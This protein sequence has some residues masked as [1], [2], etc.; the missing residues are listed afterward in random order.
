MLTETINIF[1]DNVVISS[2]KIE[3]S[4]N[5]SGQAVSESTMH[6]NDGEWKVSYQTEWEYETSG[7]VKKSTFTRMGD[8]QCLDKVIKEYKYDIRG[9]KIRE[10]TK[11]KIGDA[12]NVSVAGILV[13]ENRY[14]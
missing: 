10:T 2:T 7:K 3:Y 6:L 14:D 9:N 8:G 12:G 4:Y 11:R 1:E 5:N 13:I